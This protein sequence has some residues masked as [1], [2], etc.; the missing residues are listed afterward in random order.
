MLTSI[1]SWVMMTDWAGKKLEEISFGYLKLNCPQGQCYGVLSVYRICF[2]NTLFH[3]I[4]A[5]AMYGVSSSRDWRSSI[6]NGFWFWKFLAWAGLVVLAFFIP[7]PFFVGWGL[8]VNVPA[9]VLF[10]LIQIILLIDFSYSFSESLLEQWEATEDRKYLAFLLTMTFGAFAGCV[11]LS[12]LLYAWFGVQESNPRSGLA[13]AAMVVAY[14][15][16]LVA[17]AISSEPDGEDGTSNLCNPLNESGKTKTT[18]MV[19][20]TVFTFLALA[21]STS[22][23]ATQSGAL[24]SDES[25]T[26][27]LSTD[28]RTES[29]ADGDD[30]GE[31]P[32]DDE[33]EGVQYNYSFFHLIFLLGSAYLS[34]LITNWDTVTIEKGN[35]TAIVGKGWVQCGLK[36][37]QGTN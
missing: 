20:G 21:Y 37:Y 25:S 6:Q 35:D 28:R 11:T 5:A 18:T 10:I 16:Y 8:Y 32:M 15:T 9:A 1:L 7:N 34:Q 29:G 33:Q 30:D 3:A 12:G 26:A 36:S 24:T 14:S 31:G 19:L 23:A 17:S 2:A 13:Q 27:L 22:R 4:F